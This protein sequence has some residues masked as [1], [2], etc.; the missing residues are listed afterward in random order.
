MFIIITVTIITVLLLLLPSTMTVDYV[1]IRLMVQEAGGRFKRK[2]FSA[3]P[4]GLG[5]TKLKKL[6]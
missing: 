6:R 2:V 1:L 3:L 4:H 5:F